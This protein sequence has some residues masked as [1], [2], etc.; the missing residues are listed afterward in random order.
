M[1][2]HRLPRVE[3]VQIGL[4][5]TLLAGAILAFGGAVWWARPA[6]ALILLGLVAATLA[7]AF[8]SGGLVLLRS[9]LSLLGLLAL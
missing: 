3:R 1:T 7:R 9:P 2:S 4:I 8:T 5:V 6:G